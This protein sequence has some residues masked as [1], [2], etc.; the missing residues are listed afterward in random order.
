MLHGFELFRQQDASFLF[1]VPEGCFI[2]LES[3]L[4]DGNT[5]TC[6]SLH[7]SVYFIHVTPSMIKTHTSHV[8]LQIS[9]PVIVTVVTRNMDCSN[10]FH[11]K[12]GRKQQQHTLSCADTNDPCHFLSVSHLRNQNGEQA[13]IYSDRGEY[14]VCRFSCPMGDLWSIRAAHMREGEVCDVILEL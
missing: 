12:V 8:S 6:L 13:T 14:R 10:P 4:L 11:I 9:T 2:P 7:N 1:S 3:A 5:T